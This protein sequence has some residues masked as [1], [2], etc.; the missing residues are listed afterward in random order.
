MSEVLKFEYACG[1]VPKDSLGVLNNFSENLFGFRTYIQTFPTVGYF[2]YFA[3]LSI[4]VI[5]E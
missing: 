1:T 3:E 5:G 4:G 2:V